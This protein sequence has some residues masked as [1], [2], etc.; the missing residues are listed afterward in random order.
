MPILRAEGHEIYAL[1]WIGHGRSDKP[2]RRESVTFELHMRTIMAFVN[3]V[4][5]KGAVLVGHSWGG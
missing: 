1:D 2:I 4:Q 3:H 5:L